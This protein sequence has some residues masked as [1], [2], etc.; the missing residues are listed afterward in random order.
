MSIS[1]TI[2]P[3]YQSTQLRRFIVLV[4]CLY[5]GHCKL[6]MLSEAQPAGLFNVEANKDSAQDEVFAFQRTASR[7]MEMQ[8]GRLVGRM[9]KLGEGFRM[10]CCR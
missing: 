1:S 8:V 6:V 10:S 4:D 2:T 7:L 5:E 3:T 9:R